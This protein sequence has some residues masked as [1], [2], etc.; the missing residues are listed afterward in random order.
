MGQTKS[1]VSGATSSFNFKGVEGFHLRFDSDIPESK[2]EAHESR[3][4]KILQATVSRV[5]EYSE[6][7]S[8]Y[9]RNT[10]NQ[11]IRTTVNPVLNRNAG[12]A[13]NGSEQKKMKKVRKGKTVIKTTS[14]ADDESKGSEEMNCNF[15]ALSFGKEGV[16][17]FRKDR[18]FTSVEQKIFARAAILA[19]REIAILKAEYIDVVAV[20]EALIKQEHERAAATTEADQGRFLPT[21]IR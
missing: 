19:F 9:E 14:S 17:C 18:E 12:F 13:V 8:Q 15:I 20:S 1:K 16:F 5:N 11:I 6:W 10:G 21:K 4:N 3:V 2:R 7:L